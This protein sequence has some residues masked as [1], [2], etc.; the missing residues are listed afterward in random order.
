MNAAWAKLQPS[1]FACLGPKL[2]VPPCQL[3]PTVGDMWEHV[4]GLPYVLGP[5]LPAVW[6]AGAASGTAG[7]PLVLGHRESPGGCTPCQ[8]TLVVEKPVCGWA[9]MGFSCCMSG[10]GQGGQFGCPWVFSGPEEPLV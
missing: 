4:L 5:V 2:L 9:G 3:L 1:R 6:E 7:Q 8:G 10:L